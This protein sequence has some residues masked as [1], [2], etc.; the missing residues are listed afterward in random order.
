MNISCDNET[1]GCRTSNFLW[2]SH[3][4][5]LIYIE[6]PKN[7][8]STIK[9]SF[10]IKISDDHIIEAYLRKTIFQ[11]STNTT[12]QPIGFGNLINI[13]LLKKKM[14]DFMIKIDEGDTETVAQGKFG[15]QHSFDSPIEL[16]ARNPDYQV[17]TVT[18][19]PLDRFMSGLNMFYNV[20]NTNRRLKRLSHSRLTFSDGIDVNSAAQDI[21]SAPNHHFE[22][23][24]SF[25]GGIPASQI[26]LVPLDLVTKFLESKLI[27]VRIR[28]VATAKLF[29]SKE[30]SHDNLTK[31]T[32]KYYV[33]KI[34]FKEA[35]TYT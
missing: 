18:R 17:F 11:K 8:C 10:D 6:V 32:A 23:V 22:P 2:I 7:A 25:C 4:L 1:C 5:K 3:K 27:K 20:K 26:T 15:F 21:L 30:L 29:T 33:D 16:A 14:N 13:K 19:D 9:A 31:I 28:N 12:L 35:A 24:H 34:L